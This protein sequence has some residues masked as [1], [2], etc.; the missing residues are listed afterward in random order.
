MNSEGHCCE[1]GIKSDGDG[2]CQCTKNEVYDTTI[3]KCTCENGEKQNE[4]GFCCPRHAEL[5]LVS[6]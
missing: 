6:G 5:P 4:L 3:G 2:K 1:E